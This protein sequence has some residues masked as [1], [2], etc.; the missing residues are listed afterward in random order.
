MNALFAS[1]VRVSRSFVRFLI[2]YSFVYFCSSKGDR[3]DFADLFACFATLPLLDGSWP[4][5]SKMQISL[6]P[7]LFTLIVDIYISDDFLTLAF[8]WQVFGCWLSYDLEVECQVLFLNCWPDL[9]W[10]SSLLTVSPLQNLTSLYN[11]VKKY[12]QCADYCLK[13]WI[14]KLVI[15]GY[16]HSSSFLSTVIVCPFSCIFYLVKLLSRCTF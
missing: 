5:L 12:S 10:C 16:V 13:Y 4:L 1:A 11:R 6:S 15:V 7:W 3:F 9:D 8:V 2:L 14:E